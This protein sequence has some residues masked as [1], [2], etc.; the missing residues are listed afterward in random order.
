VGKRDKW[1][2][3]GV[4]IFDASGN[5]RGMEAVI[6]DLAG[7]MDGLTTEQKKMKLETLDMREQGQKAIL[8]LVNNYS[9]FKEI[10][11]ETKDSHDA[12]A[13]AFKIQMD[14]FDAQAKLFKT[15]L[16]VA[17][18][19]LGSVILPAL[20]VAL[21][22][23]NEA[24]REWSAFD[25]LKNA[26]GG[27]YFDAYIENAKKLFGLANYIDISKTREAVAGLSDSTREYNEIVQSL[28][29]S[30]GKVG[31][32]PIIPDI[33]ITSIEKT[34]KATKDAADH[35]R[36][37]HINLN[38]FKD[39]LPEITGPVESFEDALGTT[40]STGLSGA[41]R[42]ARSQA[43][44]ITE[45]LKEAGEAAETAGKKV[46]DKKKD[47]ADYAEYVGDL[48]EN[49]GIGVENVSTL[50][51]ILANVKQGSFDP[52]TLGLQAAGF[53]IAEMKKD[54]TPAITNWEGVV[55]V[56]GTA[57]TAMQTLN[58]GL[59]AFNAELNLTVVDKLQADMEAVSFKIAE[60]A[61]EVKAYGGG[62]FLGEKAKREMEAL[63]AEY[64]RL[65]LQAEDYK[66][67][68]ELEDTYEENTDALDLLA[69]KWIDLD[70]KF[71]DSN[72][73]DLKG[74]YEATISQAE[75]FL[76]KL[77]PQ[78]S[79]FQ[80]L[81][82]RIEAAKLVLDGYISSM[83]EYDK[84]VNPAPPGAEVNPSVGIGVGSYATGGY[85]PNAGLA[86]LHGNEFVLNSDAVAALGVPRLERFNAGD[87]GA[88]GGS[89]AGAATVVN[90][91]AGN[92]T[93][94]TWYKISDKHIQ[95]RINTRTRKFQVQANPYA[96]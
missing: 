29:N 83:K 17:L 91:I 70:A 64:Q 20:T 13:G 33:A 62:S 24:A 75:L 11:D 47:W 59:K 5:F 69:G 84:L 53:L 94:E 66:K 14:T 52:I 25:W 48:A 67:A 12:M 60:K 22:E 2:D 63:R 68:F 10:I 95:P 35:V 6:G 42:G 89:R 46:G 92:T 72:L 78:S 31:D 76:G 27:A 54:H 39:D 40:S 30:Y 82:D 9:R 86:M 65:A 15:E 44:L 8:A 56:L 41:M 43:V 21:R 77:D 93:P 7:Q 58:D 37:L 19:G 49:L 50:V 18:E 71:G 81:K 88:L 4:A 87:A 1:E 74:L 85:V 51:G 80:T 3:L 55:S 57:G 26:F 16:N 45:P 34:G 28:A 23:T 96:Q 32:K 90:I 79:A 36:A 61:A 38:N 73:G